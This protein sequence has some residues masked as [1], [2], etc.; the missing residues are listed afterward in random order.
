MTALLRTVVLVAAVALLTS[1]NLNAGATYSEKGFWCISTATPTATYGGQLY[2]HWPSLT[3]TGYYVESVYFMAVIHRWNPN[4][5][6]FQEYANLPI[7]PRPVI[8]SNYLTW[9][10]GLASAA[11][12]VPL[13]TNY[14]YWKA[15]FYGPLTG[16]PTVAL[17]KGYYKVAEY[18]HW[19]T[20]ANGST[21]ATFLPKQMLPPLNPLTVPG[22]VKNGYC[23][24]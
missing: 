4:T 12:P 10:Y 7:N 2:I 19:Q 8:P 5:Q 18:Y 11:G 22:A 15:G 17:P 16:N 3:S 14:N 6:T 9:Y 23:Q 1:S 20:G 24:I 21:W 13:D